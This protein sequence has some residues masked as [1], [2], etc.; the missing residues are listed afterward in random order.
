MYFYVKPGLII[1]LSSLVKHN[2]FR[3]AAIKTSPLK[4]SGTNNCSGAVLIAK[5]LYF[6]RSNRSK[7]WFERYAFSQ[8]T[9]HLSKFSCTIAVNSIFIHRRKLSNFKRQQHSSLF[10]RE[11]FRLYILIVI[12]NRSIHINHRWHFN[13]STWKLQR[14]KSVP[15]W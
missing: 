3:H 8:R 4:F 10:D 1:S 12:S 7:Y 9:L 2:T 14:T 13:H 11:P 15:L 5:L 6:Y